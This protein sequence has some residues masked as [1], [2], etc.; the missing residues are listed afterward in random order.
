MWRSSLPYFSVIVPFRN[1]EA[2]VDRAIN[3][4]KRQSFFNF[5]A[6]LVDDKSEDNSVAVARQLIGNDP[7]FRVV[8]APKRSIGAARNHG[9]RLAQGFRLMFLDADDDLRPNTLL[10]LFLASII[11]RPNVLMFSARARFEGMPTQK[12][13]TEKRNLILRR[14]NKAFINKA[15]PDAL[16]ELENSGAYLHFATLLSIET[17]FLRKSN[18]F[19]TE[20]VFHEDVVFTF[21]VV[22]QSELVTLIPARLYTRT[23]RPDSVTGD[24]G[25]KNIADLSTAMVDLGKRIEAIPTGSDAHRSALR[26]LADVRDYQSRIRRKICRT[27]LL[28]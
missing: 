15:G 8:T 26:I 16:V 23:I 6:I 19:F 24:A 28:E 10:I 17:S 5:E 7:R 1:E 14:H 18:L 22:T 27:E 25:R 3:S 4:L 12:R 20:G 9:I 13:A 21:Q 2:Y 11:F